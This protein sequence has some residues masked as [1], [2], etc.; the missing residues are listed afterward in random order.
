MLFNSLEYLLL[1]L[2]LVTIVYFY[3]NRFDWVT[4]AKVWLVLAS[5]VFY[6]RLIPVF[7]VLLI[8][9][10]LFNFF[11][12]RQIHRAIDRN[13]GN[14]KVWLIFALAVNLGVLGYFKYA[15][16]FVDTVVALTGMNLS[17][18]KIVLPL[19]ISFF[20]F[21]QI[22]YLVDVYRRIAHEYNLIHYF[23]F[24]TYFPHLVAGPI[25]HHKEMM[26]Q[27]ADARNNAVNWDNIFTGLFVFSLGLFK[28]VIV[29]DQFALWANAGYGSERELIFH[30][31]WITSL[32]YTMQ[33]YFD[34]SGYTDMAIGAS[35]MLNIK[36]PL[37]FNS[38]YKA[39]NIQDFWQRWHMTLSR[40]LRDYIYI[41]LGG[42]RQ[43]PLRT[44]LNLVIT[45][46]L[47]GL[48]HGANWTF[49]V[50]GALHG[51]ATAIHKAWQ[52]RGYRM[53]GLLG[54]ALTFF[55][56]NIT[57]IFFAADNFADAAR[58][59]RGMAGMNGF[60][61]GLPSGDGLWAAV[62]FNAA[63]GSRA[64]IGAFVDSMGNTAAVYFVAWPWLLWWS[65]AAL[66]LPNA[67]EMAPRIIQRPLL[68]LVWI[69]AALVPP[70]FVLTFMSSRITEFIYF[71]F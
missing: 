6:C 41:P 62:Y 63:A 48:W 50:W 70:L 5:F 44:Y 37:N 15:N 57:W 67:I 1:F 71:N 34:F 4:A 11:M 24:V 61:D 56:V 55:F 23:L 8:A 10:I 38:P 40:W 60:G 20:T 53:P 65:A 31:A 42:N 49:V 35:L 9:S 28:K 68:P 12:G 39:V 32:S 19:G 36:L 51:A 3:L 64:E 17:L 46:L 52:G 30:E 22:A 43:G 47:G 25:L 58:V 13:T 2:P 33:I 45:F 27:F 26:P 66:L 14:S 54:W 18:A 59:L 69:S 7:G 21:T 29:A 16:F